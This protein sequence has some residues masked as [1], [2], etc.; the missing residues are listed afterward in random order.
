MKINI[1]IYILIILAYIVFCRYKIKEN[2][3]ILDTKDT[4]HSQLQSEYAKRFEK[5]NKM[6]LEEK[7]K[8]LIE[9]RKKRR[10]KHFNAFQS[11]RQKSWAANVQMNDEQMYFQPRPQVFLAIPDAPL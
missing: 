10:Q 7:Q 4:I 3:R 9:I 5:I 2:F 8:R 1:I 6:S 11:Q